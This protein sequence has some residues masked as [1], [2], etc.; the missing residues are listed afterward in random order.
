MDLLTL[1]ITIVVFAVNSEVLLL[2]L[3]ESP[4]I[5]ILGLSCGP[6]SLLLLRQNNNSGSVGTWVSI[7]SLNNVHGFWKVNY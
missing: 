6:F 5:P 7:Y 3:K 1:H 2:V 4:T